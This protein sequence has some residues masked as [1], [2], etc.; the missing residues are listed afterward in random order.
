MKINSF[1]VDIQIR[2]HTLG[3]SGPVSSVGIATDYGMDGPVIESR[4]GRDFSHKSRP[5]LGPT[6]PPL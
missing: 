4:W 6:Q 2:H 3:L 1:P 5:V